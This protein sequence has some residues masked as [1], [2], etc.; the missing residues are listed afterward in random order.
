MKVRILKGSYSF[1]DEILGKVFEA[2]AVRRNGVTVGYRVFIHFSHGKDKTEISAPRAWNF[3][4][5]AVQEV[6]E[7]TPLSE[8]GGS[9]FMVS[10]LVVLNPKS[11]FVGLGCGNSNPIHTRG[12][13]IRATD[14]EYLHSITV[15]WEN[16]TTNSYNEEDLIQIKESQNAPRKNRQKPKKRNQTI[17]YIVYAD[18]TDYEIRRVK[19]VVVSAEHKALHVDTDKVIAENLVIRQNV[20]VPFEFMESIRVSTPQGDTC[21][22][23]KD[24]VLYS[25]AKDY[26]KASPFK[27]QMH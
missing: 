27:T 26:T 9:K 24:G 3:M 15:T 4:A 1:E 23:F 17:V 12:V 13:V 14:P 19:H 22:Y 21:Y 5:S 11:K 6:P 18:G 16:G 7:D 10:D 2:E 8:K 20:S 25:S